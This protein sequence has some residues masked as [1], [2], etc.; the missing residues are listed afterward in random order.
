M[1]VLLALLFFSCSSNGQQPEISMKEKG[2]AN[3]DSAW[4]AKLTPEQYY[5]CFQKG[6]EPPGSGK[7]DKF[8]KPGYYRCVACG[9][10]LFDAD[11]KFDS[12]S[13][14]PSFYDKHSDS[15]VVLQKDTSYGMIRTEVNCAQCG[16]HLGHVFDDGPRPTGLRFCINSVALEFVPAP[17]NEQ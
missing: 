3:T 4:K 1:Y 2:M 11:T 17:A 16:A 15:S 13:G 10:R 14:W 7:Y 12:G 8:Y 6:T 9:T 5:V